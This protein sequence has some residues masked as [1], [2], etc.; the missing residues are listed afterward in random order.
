[1]KANSSVL[2]VGAAAALVAGLVAGCSTPKIEVK[3]NKAGEIK[4]NGVSKIALADFN[5]L[6][7]DAFKG[8]KSADAETCALVKNAV[9][10]AFYTSPMYQ[11]SDLNIEKDIHEDNAKLVKNRF[12]A[13]V[14][15]RL[16]WQVTPEVVT[17]E[18]VKTTLS[19]WNNVPYKQKVGKK[20]VDMVAQVTTET[21]DVIQ[22]M[23][24]RTREATLMLTLSIYR[25]AYNGNVEKI[26]DTYQVTDAGFKLIDGKMTYETDVVGFKDVTASDKLKEASKDKGLLA[27]VKVENPLAA[28]E[29]PKDPRHDANGKVILPQETISMPTEL[30]AKLALVSTV[31]KSLAAKLA[32]TVETFEV[33]PDFGDARL[34]NLLRN[35]AYGSAREYALYMLRTKLGRQ[36]CDKI[37]EFIPEMSDEC[38]YEVPDSQEKFPEYDEELVNDMIKNGLNLYAYTLGVSGKAATALALKDVGHEKLIK[39]L[40]SQNLDT[41]FYALGLCHET[42]QNLEEA[43]ECYRF[44][45]NVKATKKAA[46]GLAR[47]SLALGESARLTQTRKAKKA[48][49]KKTSLVD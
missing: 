22:I 47:V 29:P 34:E 4:L 36:A 5:S 6:E 11:I 10:S 23:D 16:W 42:S 41:Y 43:L 20:D 33:D 14:Y 19:T 48:A 25:V 12:D 45:F 32:P 49:A 3:M 24:S 18:P 30:Q 35:G 15:G 7:G 27:D 46:I 17:K 31:T 26:V 21:R 9:A 40:G 2:K 38:D 8:V 37:S 1:M 28:K 44:A 39:Y 13:F